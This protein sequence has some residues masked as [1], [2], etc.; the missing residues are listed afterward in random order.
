MKKIVQ[1]LN[2]YVNENAEEGIISFAE[3]LLSESI[4]ETVKEEIFFSLPTKI[5]CSII[6]KSATEDVSLLKAIVQSMS[7]HK[8]EESALVLN[9]LSP[10]KA[11]FDECIDI[12]SCLET[13]PICKR[14][15]NLHREN[16]L[17][18]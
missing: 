2:K 16:E 8:G 3:E 9:V 13:S 10:E 1:K 18:P 5:I 11:T 12:I 4:E 7:K 15:G 6:G 14:I 17:L